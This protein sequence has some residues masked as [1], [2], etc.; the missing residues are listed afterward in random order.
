MVLHIL[1]DD[2]FANYAIKQFADGGTQ[3]ELVVIPPGN[4]QSFVKSDKVQMLPYPS[5]QFTNLLSRLGSYSAIVFHGLFWPFCEDILKAV[6]DSV[7]V[8]WYFW[9]GELYSRKEIMFSFIAPITKFFHRLHLIKK[10]QKF[11]D[12]FKWQLPLHLYNRIDYC[13]TD[14]L[15]EYHFVK[16]YLGVEMSYAWYTYYS[17]E[18]TLGSLIKQRSVGDN[19]LF[20][21]SSAIENNMFDAAFRLSLPKYRKLLGLRQVIMPM[22]YGTPWCKTLMLKLGPKF[23]RNF[24]P[25]VD[26]LSLKEYNQR[27]TNCSTIILPYFSSAGKGNIIV[28]L[29]LGMRVY[30]SE[31]SI[32]YQHFKRIGAQVFAFESEFVKYGCERLP[33]EIVQQNRLVLQREYGKE[34]VY[35]RAKQL[36]NLLDA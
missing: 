2:K 17:L 10:R 8:A 14:E 33:E 26:F 1:T 28:A 7:K 29:W 31:R 16:Q 19:L 23:F 5:E 20:C 3:S 6:P 11:D 18:E 30:L 22:G 35:G 12:S 32:A 9:G 21:N 25:I 34:N 24:H 13:L 4:G 27:M 15:E 36:T